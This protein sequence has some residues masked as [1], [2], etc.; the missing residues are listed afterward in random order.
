MTQFLARWCV[1]GRDDTWHRLDAHDPEMAAESFVEY[2]ER[3]SA[4]YPVGSGR[5]EVCVEVASPSLMGAKV[6]P[7]LGQFE[8]RGEAEPHYYAKRLS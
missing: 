4:D 7:L 6:G 2:H 1:I 3:T 8:V 5:E